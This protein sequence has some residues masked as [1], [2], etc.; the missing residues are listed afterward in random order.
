MKTCIVLAIFILLLKVPSTSSTFCSA[1]GLVEPG[2]SC[3]G[4]ANALGI[5]IENLIA[6]NQGLNCDQLWVG[7]MLC[8]QQ[9]STRPDCTKFYRIN[10]GDYCYKIWTENGLSERQLQEMNSG[11][12]CNRIAVGQ[13]LCVSFDPR[14]STPRPQTT[15]ATPFISSTER[16]AE[17]SE[18][19]PLPLVEAPVKCHE[20]TTIKTGDTCSKIAKE[21]HLPL[22]ELQNQ[23]NCDNLKIGDTLCV[24]E[25]Y[26]CQHRYLIQSSDTCHSIGKVFKLNPLEIEEMNPDLKCNNLEK[27]Q[28]CVWSVEDR[29]LANMTC[30]KKI[31]FESSTSCLEIARQYSITIDELQFLNP[32]IPCVRPLAK[33][34]ELCV[35]GESTIEN[36][37]S[38]QPVPFNSTCSDVSQQF[39][40]SIPLMLNLNPTLNCDKLNVTEQVCVGVGA[41]KT[42]KCTDTMR[43]IPGSDTCQKIL[44]ETQLS[45]SQLQNLNPT[46]DCRE[47]LKL[48]SL[49]CIGNLGMDT[50]TA[51]EA[52]VTSLNSLVPGL[53][54]KFQKFQNDPSEA[55]S[56][57]LN[58]LLTSSIQRPE[59]NSKLKSLYK[60]NIIIR[61]ALDSQHPL[62][63]QEYCNQVWYTSTTQVIKDCFCGIEELLIYCQALAVQRFQDNER[64]LSENENWHRSKRA[65]GCQFIT[66]YSGKSILDMM[67]GAKNNCWGGGCS[68]PVGFFEAN[69]DA[70]LCFPFIEYL[71][72]QDEVRVCY[73]NSDG[74]DN[75][76]PN[77]A[78]ALKYIADRSV[79]SSLKL[80]A[81]GSE[82][83]KKLLAADA[84]LCFEIVSVNYYGLVGKLN[85]GSS[86]NL[87]AFK[88][89]GGATIKVHDLA[90]PN[91]CEDEDNECEDYCK[92]RDW[93]NGKAYG[94][95]EGRILAVFGWDGIKV[96]DEKFNQPSKLGCEVGEKAAV[97]LRND[98]T[99]GNQE[100]RDV[101][102]CCWS[103][104]TKTCDFELM[105]QERG[106]SFKPHIFGRTVFTCEFVDRN[107][108]YLDDKLG[109]DVYGG[110]SKNQGKKNFYYVAKN[111]G[112]Y[113]GTEKYKEDTLVQSW[114]NPCEEARQPENTNS[115]GGE[116]EPTG[117]S[118]VPAAACGKRIVGYYTGW[119]E[120]E[121]TENQLRKLTH[122]VFA[123]VAMKPDGSVEFGP[124]SEDDPGPEAGVKAKRRFLD[125]KKKAR[126]ANSGVQ[127]LFAVGGWDNSQY[128]PS[129][130]ADSGK[131]AHFINSVANFIE[132]YGIDGVDL[133]WEYPAEKGADKNNH[134]TLI[135]EL[136][137]R[138]DQL[139]ASKNRRSKYLITLATAAGEWN[140][141]EGYDLNGIL[142]YADFLNVM[143]YDYYGAWASKWGAYTGPPSPLYFG[144]L[145]GFSGKLN[146][147]FTMK[148]YSCKTKKP[149]MLNMG[150]PFYGRFWE[151][152]LEPIR[153]EDGMW[154]TA[155]EVNGEFEGGYVGWRNLEKQ[156]WNKGA[157]TWHDKTKT[158]YIFNSGARKFLGFENERSLKEKMN[159]ATGKN[160]GGIMIWALDLDDDADTLLN[161]VSSTNLCAGSGNAY[162]CNPV[163]DVRW[164]TPENS[165]ETVQGMCGKSAKLINGFYPVC[166]PDDPGFSCCGAA[167]YCGSEEEYCGCDTCIDYRK[168]PM[169][170]VKEPVKPSREVQ[171]YLMNDVDGKRGRCGK[172]APPLNGKLAICNPDDNSKHC[173]SNGGY[174]GTGKEYCECD[175]CVDYKKQ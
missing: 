77:D 153:G 17:N 124:V 80:C 98:R 136:R 93:P 40:M 175:G 102:R 87:I 121:I 149:G 119:G 85:V 43:V 61:R 95:M 20:Y 68:I 103:K 152:V 7:Q 167:G 172:D 106:F 100:D 112:M 142:Q 115:G 32:T 125:M 132:S 113:F 83:I 23:Y 168:D 35:S 50:R 38:I 82:L 170:I 165:D 139:A 49:V 6:L 67:M 29:T 91:M 60:T 169:L 9:S 44:N 128:F 34:T 10:S 84:G 154:R 120:R 15:T 81:I 4:I 19:Q 64:R 21:F 164:W 72:N 122:V 138:L 171:W 162:V 147:D 51:Q 36:C 28:I 114:K 166:D 8:T 30:T 140:L 76:D 160:L 110:K 33:R 59:V 143:T 148:F 89:S 144:S 117:Q 13:Q 70:S 26:T 135:R 12:D 151:N 2:D 94:H 96:F 11:L 137:Q 155:Q 127:I 3:W 56:N 92:W 46:L 22:Q 79:D 53:M 150:V 62:P 158:P 133:D 5:S 41:F 90:F 1:W 16:S 126:S 47:S 71:Q 31:V 86:L 99:C 130:A 24:S 116:A 146:A 156:G 14:F 129:T 163:D 42:S 107:L 78:G 25:K 37:A 48:N 69:M 75:A 66:P 111:D 161:L 159:Y 105:E 173:C 73:D 109:F 45:L 123:F 58:Q 174:C 145:K 18:H 88:L 55:N 57:D 101:W 74:C 108:D 141:R 52:V 65:I 63:R 39:S 27:R 118:S 54:E 104:D 131:R 134:V 157:A 97:I